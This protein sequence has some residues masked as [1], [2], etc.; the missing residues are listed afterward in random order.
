[1]HRKIHAGLG[2]Q[3]FTHISKI[4]KM[5]KMGGMI[6]VDS[7]YKDLEVIID[8]LSKKGTQNNK[9]IESIDKQR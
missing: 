7:W 8:R 2:H 9:N 6:T 1:M 4:Q 5:Q 3:V